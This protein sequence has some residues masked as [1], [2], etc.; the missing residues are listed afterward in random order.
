MSTWF[1]PKR[2]ISLKD[3]TLLLALQN[4]IN[5]NKNIIKGNTHKITHDVY[6]I[7]LIFFVLFFSVVVCVLSRHFHALPSFKHAKKSSK[8][9]VASKKWNQVK[10]LLIKYW[11]TSE[12]YSSQKCTQLSESVYVN[13]MLRYHFV[14]IS[15]LHWNIY[16]NTILRIVENW[17][18]IKI[19]KDGKSWNNFKLFAINKFKNIYKH[20]NIKLNILWVEMILKIINCIICSRFSSNLSRESI[21]M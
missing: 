8:I 2:T 4:K 6:S 18:E 20:F 16:N 9:N 1:I 21:N 10:K 12:I 11:K 15:L 13:F 17:K 3:S 7:Y 14:S 5:Q 19:K